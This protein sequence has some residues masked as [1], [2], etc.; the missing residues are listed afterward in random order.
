MTRPAHWF[1]GCD[2]IPMRI[3][4]LHMSALRACLAAISLALVLAA[5][6]AAQQRR[7]VHAPGPRK[8][9]EG[10]RGPARPHRH[11]QSRRPGGT[12]V[13]A[14]ASGGDRAVS[15]SVRLRRQQR[16]PD[17]AGEGEAAVSLQQRQR[18]GRPGEARLHRTHVPGHNAV[19]AAGKAGR[20]GDAGQCRREVR[21]QM[22]GFCG[23][24]LAAGHQP[25]NL[26]AL[27]QHADLVVQNQ[28]HAASHG[29]QSAAF[30]LG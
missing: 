29:L 18:L 17:G 21:Q 13:S 2:G 1:G 8:T 19:L 22:V 20:T 16:P 14:P 7:E 23:E 25:A 11:G 9:V 5:P 24:E 28:H 30:D 3:E 26:L 12:C 4:V 15:D 27:R 10:R 6:A